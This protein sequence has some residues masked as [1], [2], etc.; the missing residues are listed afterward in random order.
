MPPKLVESIQAMW[1]K[2]SEVVINWI[3]VSDS[4]Y[5]NLLGKKMNRPVTNS[6]EKHCSKMPQASL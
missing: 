5:W 2:T 3:L 6:V 1:H 4:L